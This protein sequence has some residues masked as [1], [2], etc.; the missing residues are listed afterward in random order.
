MIKEWFNWQVV[1]SVLRNLAQVAGGS[2]MAGGVINEEQN[3]LLTGAVVSVG[4]LAFSLISAHF[5]KSAIDVAGG[6]ANVK[7]VSKSLISN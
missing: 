2:L 1:Q 5:K 3:T 7:E 6:K 4:A